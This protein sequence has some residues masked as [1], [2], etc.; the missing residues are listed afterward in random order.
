MDDE[1][2]SSG[3]QHPSDSG[4]GRWSFAVG[5]LLGIQ[6]RIH[7][8]FVLIVLIFLVASQDPEGPTPAS[9]MIWLAVIF[10]CI[11]AH[12]LSHSIVARRRGVGVRA[13]MLLPIGGVSQLESLPQSPAD[14]LAI[15]IAGP[16]TS[17]AIAGVAAALAVAGSDPLL[18]VNFVSSALLPRVAWFNLLI[19][20]FNLLPAF[21]LDGGRVFRSLLERRMDLEAATRLAS[22]AGRALAGAMVVAGFLFNPWLVFIGL[23]VWLGATGEET[24]TLV[25][26]RLA[27]RRVRDLMVRDPVVVDASE[28]AHHLIAAARQTAQREFPVLEDDRYVGM[29]TVWDAEDAPA[30]TR[31]GDITENNL[32]AVSPEDSVEDDLALLAGQARAQALAVVKDGRVVGLLRSED[33]ARLLRRA[34]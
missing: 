14:E 19:G 8:S 22:T 4:A 10:T 28:P 3:R 2:R 25:H 30:G 21:P 31:I 33:V 20:L 27:G 26:V 5:R 11:T 7:I 24:A 23:F 9:A 1:G 32:P 34:A 15:S 13:I 18:P 17:L 12:E 6:I 16:L 29:V